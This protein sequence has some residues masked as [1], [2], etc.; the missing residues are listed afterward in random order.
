[1]FSLW[2]CIETAILT[3]ENS[4]GKNLLISQ[5]IL[6]LGPMFIGLL[7]FELMHAISSLNVGYFFQNTLYIDITSG[8]ALMKTI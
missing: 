2:I 6:I 5:K 1:M 8:T 7:F 3:V 4:V